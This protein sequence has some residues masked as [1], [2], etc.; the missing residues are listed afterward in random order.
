MRTRHRDSHTPTNTHHCV[1]QT[2]YDFVSCSRC[3]SRLHDCLS[4]TSVHVTIVCAVVVDLL[5]V[6]SLLLIAIDVICGSSRHTPTLNLHADVCVLWF[7]RCQ[8]RGRDVINTFERG[9]G[10]S[11]RSDCHS[12]EFLERSKHITS[13]LF[14]FTQMPASN[15]VICSN[16]CSFFRVNVVNWPQISAKYLYLAIYNKKIQVY[17]T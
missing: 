17:L 14:H 7:F 2:Y 6:T 15:T 1:I 10:A 12:C 4:I 11:R 9:R 16:F 5:V 13:L 3:R 8:Q